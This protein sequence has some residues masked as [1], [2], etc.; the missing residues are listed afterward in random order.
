[1]KA[2]LRWRAL[3]SS[4]ALSEELCLIS[5]DHHLFLYAIKA[6]ISHLTVS[7]LTSEGINSFGNDVQSSISYI[8]L[9]QQVL[10]T[11]SSPRPYKN[12]K[13]RLYGKKSNQIML[14]RIENHLSVCTAGTSWARS[15]RATLGV[16]VSKQ[17]WLLDPIPGQWQEAAMLTSPHLQHAALQALGCRGCPCHVQTQLLP[18]GL[19]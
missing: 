9:H 7:R 11:A 13:T 14:L 18:R 19:Q 4:Q 12:S 3:N 17:N 15:L 6:I 10:C 1:M 8:S 2:A 16:H 5:K